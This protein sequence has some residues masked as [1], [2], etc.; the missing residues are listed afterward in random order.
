MTTDASDTPSSGGDRSSR[1]GGGSRVSR[2][3]RLQQKPR[4]PARESERLTA[5]G[6]DAEPRVANEADAGA[7]DAPPPRLR[8]PAPP[9]DMGLPKLVGF[10]GI[11]RGRKQR[12]E[13]GGVQGPRREGATPAKTRSAGGSGG[14][15]D[16]NNG[17]VN[18]STANSRARYRA[19]L[20]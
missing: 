4:Q 10:S 18:Y 8:A 19:S 14:K 3:A 6:L 2:G 16:K 1:A 11:F 7:D 15:A 20:R 17:Y 9:G 12:A 5:A 13:G